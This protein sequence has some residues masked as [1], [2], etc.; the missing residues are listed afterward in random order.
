[1]AF[2]DLSSGDDK[3]GAS[4]RARLVDRK[5]L[6]VVSLAIRPLIVNSTEINDNFDLRG[7]FDDDND[8]YGGPQCK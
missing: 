5:I 8:E 4:S 6:D 7:S 3:S 1:M 2:V